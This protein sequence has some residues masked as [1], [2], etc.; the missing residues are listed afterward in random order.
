MKRLHNFQLRDCVIIWFQGT[1]PS[2]FLHK[3]FSLNEGHAKWVHCSSDSIANLKQMAECAKLALLNNKTEE[4]IYRN[5]E[6]TQVCCLTEEIP[7]CGLDYRYADGFRM[8]IMK[9]LSEILEP[10]VETLEEFEETRQERS[11]TY[12]KTPSHMQRRMRN[13]L[14]SA[15]TCSEPR[16]GNF[17][18]HSYNFTQIIYP[19]IFTMH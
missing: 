2:I 8:L 6:K 10:S 13:T 14:S 12:S 19:S 16:S 18:R 15:L 17:S 9:T 1:Y 11:A 4:D 5:F 7:T 3:F